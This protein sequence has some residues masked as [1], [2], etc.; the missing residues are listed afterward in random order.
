VNN[1]RYGNQAALAILSMGA[2]LMNTFG[3]PRPND[4]RFITR[5]DLLKEEADAIGGVKEWDD[6]SLQGKD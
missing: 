1:P 4:I 2:R 3:R 5:R 6:L